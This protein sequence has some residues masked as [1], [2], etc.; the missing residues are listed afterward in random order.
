MVLNALIA[1]TSF[2]LIFFVWGWID[3]TFFD[4]ELTSYFAIRYERFVTGLFLFP[5]LM[6]ITY[7]VY[8]NY[9]AGKHFSDGMLDKIDLPEDRGYLNDEKNKVEVLATNDVAFDKLFKRY[10]GYLRAI[11]G[12]GQFNKRQ[13]I[14]LNSGGKSYIGYFIAIGVFWI[15]F[16]IA[17]VATL[18]Y[19]QQHYR[20]DFNAVMKNARQTNPLYTLY[21]IALLAALLLYLIF[22]YVRILAAKL[23]GPALVLGNK[24]LNTEKATSLSQRFKEFTTVKH[25]YIK[26]PIRTYLYP[27]ALFCSCYPIVIGLVLTDLTLILIGGLAA[28]AFIALKRFDKGQVLWF[29]FHDA[30]TLYV[31]DAKQSIGFGINDIEDVIV[32]YQLTSS[33]QSPLRLSGEA[34]MLRSLA[35]RAL[36]KLLDIPELIPSTI[37]FILKSDQVYVLPLRYV[38]RNEEGIDSHEIEFFFAYWLKANGF[39]FEL[40]ESEEDAGD[41][42]AFRNN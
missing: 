27:V 31:G 13:A 11:S 38:A 19:V 10:N 3:G 14:D 21:I 25:E 18:Y 4:S 9:R 28:A 23:L 22:K 20:A 35:N 32:Q 34:A 30:K 41:W 7:V 37:H 8:W 36:K 42:R 26:P 39:Q 17:S 24:A 2:S 5:V 1:I 40:A 15:F 33:G 12:S 29:H 16:L 6:G